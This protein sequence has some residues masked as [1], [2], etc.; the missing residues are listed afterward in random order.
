MEVEAVDPS[1]LELKMRRSLERVLINIAGVACVAGLT[2]ASRPADPAPSEVARLRAH[3]DSVLQ[4][5]RIRDVSSLSPTQRE[6]RGTLI[7]R[8]ERYAAAGRFPHNH[9]V[10]GSFVPVFRDEH[11][12]LCAMAY[13][14]ASTGRTDIV[15]DVARTNNLAYLPELAKDERLRVWLD[16][17]G[18]T[19][20]EAA[21]IQPQYDGGPCFC[22]GPSPEP[23]RSAST[24]YFVLSGVGL[25]ANVFVA[26]NALAPRDMTARALRRI[27][28]IG[29]A[30]GAAQIA[31]GAMAYDL[32]GTDRAV[33]IGNIAVG[34]ATI[35]TSVWRM[36]HL[37]A[38][39][40]ATRSMSFMPIVAPKSAGLM[41]AAR[42]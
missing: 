23:Q 41:L 26:A 17:T 36:W 21:R 18:L 31:L 28:Y 3:F 34:V 32:R 37:P 40:V 4:E 5:L 15:D 24:A 20:A 38:P 19:V 25:G 42:M 27:S 9:V 22:V 29:V 1:I 10:A 14:I 30:T 12:T 33:G 13:L 11:G 35:G 16:S 8:L 2:I 39:S 7:L 6:A